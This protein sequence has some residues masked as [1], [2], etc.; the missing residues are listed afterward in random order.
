M[1]RIFVVLLS[2][3]SCLT[4]YAQERSNFTTSLDLFFWR[5]RAGSSSNWSQLI[6]APGPTQTS[7]LNG[8]PF[9]IDPGIRLG[10]KYKPKQSKWD[11]S[12][13]YSH[14][15]TKA[16]DS[17]EG[18][19]FSAYLGNFFAGNT[20]GSKFGP[21]YDSGSIH[22]QFD[23][24]VV[25]SE[26]GRNF[27]FENII[28][29]HSAIGIRLAFLNNEWF[30]HWN[31]PRSSDNPPTTYTFTESDENLENK[32]WGVGP[33]LSFELGFPITR[34]FQLVGDFTGALLWGHW[35]FADLFQADDGTKINIETSDI[36]GAATMLGMLLSL[37]W[38]R[39]YTK[40]DVRMR[41]GYGAQIWLSQMQYYN[42][43]MGRLNNLLSLQGVTFNLS[44]NF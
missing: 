3:A 32:F 19:V 7:T 14:Y 29:I 38:Q 15:Q 16:N 33:S 24:N 40:A 34:N 8:V 21:Y 31:G 22:W 25:D 36:N 43:N 1:K 27:N 42:Y 11:T 13:S 6:T 4:T 35:Q 12:F 26:V 39:E 20:D 2:I 17:V 9:K 37:D 30:T 10:L 28:D 18:R 44:V 41:L 23:Y 5:L